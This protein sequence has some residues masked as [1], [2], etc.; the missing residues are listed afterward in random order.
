MNIKQDNKSQDQDTEKLKE[1]PKWT[2]RYA[3]NRTLTIIVLMAMI[4][5]FSMFVA[6]L[7]GFSLSLAVAGFRKGNIILGCVGI[8]VLV[9]T[10]TSISIFLIIFLKK[11]GG[12]NR[13][14]I[15]QLIEQRIYG[16]EGTV[17]MPMPKSSK[18]KICLEI[19]GAVIFFICL[20]GSWHLAIKGY[21]A[22]K[23]LQP[24]SALYIV[25]FVVCG[26]YF[27]KSPRMGPIY[28]LYPILYAVH[29]ILIVAGVPIFFT[30]ENFCIFSICLPMLGYGFLPLII[31]HLYSRYAL[32]K[33]KALTHLEEGVAG[34]D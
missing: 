19:V 8:A 1:I 7:V 22:Y 30:T 28:L 32:K 12:K 27:W 3:Q 5:L 4:M 13:G 29:A 34:E 25:P 14:L 10:L 6:G 17:S 26:W 15:D 18:K 24:V 2:R 11:F 20:F 33:L 16:K 21:I 23:Y 31:G 9:S